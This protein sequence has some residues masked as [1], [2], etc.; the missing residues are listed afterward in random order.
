MSYQIFNSTL[1]IVRNEIDIFLKNY[2]VNHSYQ[3]ALSIPYFRQKFITKIINSIPN[4]HILIDQCH[5]FIDDNFFYI[6]LA[7]EK[8]LIHEKICSNIEDIVSEYNDFTNS[9]DQLIIQKK[10]KVHHS[11]KLSWWIRY[12]TT[13]PTVTYYFGPF[14]NFTEATNHSQ[15]YLEDLMDENAQE[16]TYDIEL[17]NPHQLTVIND[18]EDLQKENE[19]I[20][21]QL[22]ENES[23]NKYYKNLFLQSPDIRL[24]LDNNLIIKDINYQGNILFNL[25]VDDLNNKHFT[26]FIATD[27]LEKFLIFI[28]DLKTSNL[29]NSS[30]SNFLSLRLSFPE[31]LFLNVS[32]KISPILDP[33]GNSNGWDLSCH[34]I[35]EIQKN[36]DQFYYESRYDCL[37]NL[38]NRL[39]L[40][41]FLD[42]VLIEAEKNHSNKFAVLYLDINKFKSI[43]DTF[44]HQIGDEVL[45]IFAKRLITCV[46]NFDHVARLSG[47]E[48]MIVLSHIHSV[49]EATECAMR[50]QQ[51]LSTS[52]K[53][54]QMEIA[55][56][57]SIGIV[58]GDIK[59]SKVCDLLSR[60]D[61]AMYKAKYSEQLFSIYHC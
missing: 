10:S 15:D 22:W 16:I 7:K 50:I 6:E 48:F 25:S 52:F 19:L 58:I 35:T 36:H 18:L 26:S 43:N 24:L 1:P 42:N 32:I 56:N 57:V 28:Q 31:N 39:S 38:P 44:G 11:Q 41:E 51:V 33:K 21:R 13:K 49:Q 2:S 23:E 40:L 5:P 45:V 47:D 46:R 17:G 60:A 14:E 20:L 54:N 8:D 12:E 37:T 59:S 30:K 27:S 9:D 3:K 61:M 53:I 29:N 34:D 55:V 4:N